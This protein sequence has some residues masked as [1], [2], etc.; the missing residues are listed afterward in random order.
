VT[1]M[2]EVP[3]AGI[4]EGERATWRRRHVLLP[5][6]E[7]EFDDDNRI[8]YYSHHLV[9]SQYEQQDKSEAYFLY[10]NVQKYKQ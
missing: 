5:G 9:I 7:F 6:W 3:V 8:Y 2:Q 10:N 1:V 4:E